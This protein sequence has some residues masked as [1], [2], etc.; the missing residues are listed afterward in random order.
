[1]VILDCSLMSITFLTLSIVCGQLIK[2]SFG[3][4]GGLTLLDLAVIAFCFYG[5]AFRKV[6]YKRPPVWIKAA[7]VF[8]A[9]GTISLAITPIKLTSLELLNSASYLIRIALYILLGYFIYCGAFYEVKK[10][11]NHTLIISGIALSIIGLLQF[12]FLPDLRFLQQF[13]WD[14]HYFRAASTFLDPNFLGA[15]LVLTL[16]LWYQKNSFAKKWQIWGFALIYLTLLVTFSR[17]A[18]LAFFAGF[19]TISILSKSFKKFL[20]AAVLF[21]GLLGGFYVYQKLVAEPRGIDRSQS[22]QF[23]LGTWQQG[24][25]LFLKRPILGVGFNTYKYALKQYNLADNSF[26]SSHGSSTNDSSLLYILATTGVVGLVSYFFFLFTL[27]KTGWKEK[28]L[29][30]GIIA[31]LVQSFFANTLFFPPLLIWVILEAS[32]KE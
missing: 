5:F 30:A 20:L 27:F 12:I 3:S 21:G 10:E 31:L 29:P 4:S 1:M 24:W 25:N 15:F 13:G 11:I 28:V 22:A 2:I 14:P 17:G 32:R 23:R 19:T 9:V 16:I 26:L 6:N 8:I 18:Y 7:L